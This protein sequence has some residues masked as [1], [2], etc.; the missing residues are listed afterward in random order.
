MKPQES[1]RVLMSAIGT[2]R[3]AG[4]GRGGASAQSIWV[5]SQV[6]IPLVSSSSDTQMVNTRTLMSED[7]DIDPILLCDK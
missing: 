5:H 6:V 3:Q 2:Q 7:M 4:S 1:V